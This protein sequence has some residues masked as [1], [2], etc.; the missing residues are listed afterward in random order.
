MLCQ[1]LIALVRKTVPG[2]L[3]G[4]HDAYYV[5][6]TLQDFIR[7]SEKGEGLTEFLKHVST[8][9]PVCYIYRQLDIICT[10]YSQ[11]N[12]DGEKPKEENQTLVFT[13]VFYNLFFFSPYLAI[14]CGCFLQLLNILLQWWFSNF[15]AQ[16]SFTL[17]N[18]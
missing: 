2:Y 6:D 13:I 10:V 14:S 16:D 11:K 18:Y 8:E 7:E 9:S 12:R 15:Q 4:L 3:E 1:L 5:P 17:L